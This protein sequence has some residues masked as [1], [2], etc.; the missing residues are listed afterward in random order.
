MFCVLEIHHF[1][2]TFPSIIPLNQLL[3]EEGA[4]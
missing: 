1:L 2:G 3:Q 4:Q